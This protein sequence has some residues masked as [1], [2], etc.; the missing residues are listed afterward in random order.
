M[1]YNKGMKNTHL[2]HLEDNILN[3]GTAGGI[4]VVDLLRQFG[5]VL[6]G[7]K[8]TLTIST[9][10]DG[11]PAIVC[12]TDPVTGRFFV[13]TKSVFNKVNPKVCYDDTDIDRYYQAEILRNKLKTCL[14][15][16]SKTGISGV[17]QGDLLFTE[18]DKQF[19]KIGDDI[20]I[21]FQPNTITY[22]CLLYTSDA[23]DE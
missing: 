22:A 5:Y 2:E 21:T 4:E 3:T 15:Y 23:A 19:G 11:A 16:L 18:G 12:G 10:W 8:S 20:H 13:G 14:K 9:K 7:R 1:H 17:M 6:S